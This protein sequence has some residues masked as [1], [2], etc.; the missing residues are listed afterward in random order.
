MNPCMQAITQSNNT[1]PEIHAV[2]HCLHK[3]R[4]MGKGKLI[5]RFP[6]RRIPSNFVQFKIAEKHKKILGLQTTIFYKL[7]CQCCKKN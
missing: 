7:P 5:L 4:I 2:F 6:S 1:K 3:A